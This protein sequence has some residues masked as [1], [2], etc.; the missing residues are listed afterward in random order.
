VRAVSET[1]ADLIRALVERGAHDEA[2]AL[3]DHSMRGA[4]GPERADLLLALSLVHTNRGEHLPALAAA[5]EAG[6]LFQAAGLAGRTCDALVST[7]GILRAAGD[8]ETALSTLE[9][10]ETLARG[11]GDELRRGRVLR[12]IGIVSSVLGRHQHAQSC[13]EE[14]CQLL[15]RSAGGDEQRNAR[16]SYLNGISRRLDGAPDDGQPRPEVEAHLRDWIELAEQCTAAGQMRL[17]LMAWGNHAIVLQAAGR[18][19]EAAAALR[20]LVPRYRE[21]GMRPNEG[22]AYTEMAR[23]HETLG[24]AERARQHYRDALALLR[25]GGVVEDLLRALEGLARCEESL[26]DVAAAYAALKELRAAERQR[27]DESARQALLQRELRVELARLTHQWARQAVQDPLTGLANRRALERWLASHWPRV[28]LGQPLALVL[29]DLDHFKKI[30]DTLGHDTGD[31]VLQAVADLLRAQ[32][33][34]TDLAVRYGGEEFLLAMADSDAAAAT[35]LAERL[36]ELIASQEWSRLAPGLDVSSSFG[37]ADASEAL[38]AQAL[39][40]LADRR[41]YA[42][43]FGGRNRVVAA[44]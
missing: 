14:A 25:E 40:T 13:L 18:H 4:A 28:E 12:Q 1:T 27:K 35:P 31:L 30:N 33:R 2:H 11:V 15:G 26:G 42:A 3:A 44:G 24:D 7:A 19:R 39:L 16:L 8:H 6:E 36:R 43:K 10:A 34:A 5:V 41:L 20:A 32:C 23:C 17:A 37:V 21:F 9:H 29:L 22:L 38:D